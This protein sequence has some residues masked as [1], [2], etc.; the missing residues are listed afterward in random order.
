MKT[1]D[2]QSIE[3]DRPVSEVFDYVANPA[4]LPKWTNAF[5]S[6]D[7]EKAALRTS[8]TRARN[9]GSTSPSNHGLFASQRRL[10]GLG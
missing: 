1:F 5:K 9:R 2:V 4:N 10:R 3:I 8:V 6:A 7:H